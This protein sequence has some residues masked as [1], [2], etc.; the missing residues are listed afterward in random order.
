SS[1]K[2]NNDSKA[3]TSVESG[4]AGDNDNKKSASIDLQDIRPSQ[5]HILGAQYP[6]SSTSEIPGPRN[7]QEV[8]PEQQA[9]FFQQV[10]YS[11]DPNTSIVEDQALLERQIAEIKAQHDQ[12]LQE[13]QELERIRLEQQAHLELLQQ[14]LD[15]SRRA[16]QIE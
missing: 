12:K 3:Y 13:Q 16:T 10:R 2:W 4:G 8:Q 5:D 7:P 6:P 9:Q 11:H 14:R 15:S 1:K